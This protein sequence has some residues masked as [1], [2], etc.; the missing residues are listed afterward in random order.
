MQRSDCTDIP[1]DLE[2]VEPFNRLL[3][4]QH[5]VGTAASRCNRVTEFF[6]TGHL[7]RFAARQPH[8]FDTVD[9]PSIRPG[10]DHAQGLVP[11]DFHD[12]A[13]L[14]FYKLW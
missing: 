13:S 1:M 7:W 9:G 10:K 3:R 4:H 8:E 11:A 5:G 2:W 6:V 14:H 12:G